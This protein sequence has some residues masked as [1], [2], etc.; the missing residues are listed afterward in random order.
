MKRR[1]DR[2][3]AFWWQRLW[4]KDF[5]DVDVLRMIFCFSRDGIDFKIQAVDITPLLPVCKIKFCVPVL[6]QLIAKGC[7]IVFV[8]IGP[9][10]KPNEMK[11][12]GRI[13]CVNKAFKCI[14]RFFSFI[15]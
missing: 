14:Q 1:G 8:R 13:V 6:Q 9:K 3:L 5:D 4:Q 10:M 7:A 15:Q 2:Q 11:C 12:V